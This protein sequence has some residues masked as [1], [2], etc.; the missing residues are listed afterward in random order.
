MLIV[1]L[2]E[3]VMLP[4]GAAHVPAAAFGLVTVRF[5]S[6]M[7][8]LLNAATP[9]LP[10]CPVTPAPLRLIVSPLPI[11]PGATVL[12]S[13]ATPTLLVPFQLHRRSRH[14]QYL[15]AVMDK[16]AP[17][18]TTV[19]VSGI[20]ASATTRLPAPEAPKTTALNPPPS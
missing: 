2:S 12:L 4:P 19:I 3:I 14:Q 8:P 18:A 11:V 15:A 20:A 1:L 17:C 6:A 13:T 9:L 16:Y 7:V 10:A 5:S